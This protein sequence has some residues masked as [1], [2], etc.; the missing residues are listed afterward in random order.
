MRQAWD[1]QA[2]TWTRWARTP[3]H[4]SYRNFHGERFFELVPPPGRLTLDLGAGEGRVA[5]D[6]RGRGH[7]VVEVEA[8]SALA[9]ASS[10]MSDAT[11]VNAD[12]ARLPIATGVD[13]MPAA[14]SEAARVL[15]PGGHLVMA[16]VHPVNSAGRFEPLQPGEE[17]IDRPFVVRGSYFA[18]RRYVEDIARDGLPMRFESEH[19]PLE[20]YA[21]ALEHAGF[22]I[23]A[24]REVGEPDPASKWSKMPLFLD[25]RAVRN[26][27]EPPAGVRQA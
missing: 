15:A 9:R 8:S 24:M 7:V 26:S 11:V 3:G 1:R 5:R 17:D 23:D 16:I 10:Q 14:I 4:D 25:L 6:L 21:R 13:E 22:S 27:R 19:R 12:V 18:E 20:T 2:E